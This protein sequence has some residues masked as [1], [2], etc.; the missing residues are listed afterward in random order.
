[1]EKRGEKNT[2]GLLS[3]TGDEA[4]RG[5]KDEGPLRTCES[6]CQKETDCVSMRNVM[7]RTAR[8][9]QAVLSNE[10]TV[11]SSKNQGGFETTIR[12]SK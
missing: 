5:E 9:L 4:P 1:M 6:K 7:M 3:A 10:E 8:V 11:R 12:K 2:T